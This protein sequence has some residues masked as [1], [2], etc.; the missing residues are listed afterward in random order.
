ME[1][2]GYGSKRAADCPCPVPPLRLSLIPAWPEEGGPQV[3]SHRPV[4]GAS[5]NLCWLQPA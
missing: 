5:P 2:G 4:H 3:Q 1:L